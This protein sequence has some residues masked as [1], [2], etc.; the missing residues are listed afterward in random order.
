MYLLQVI[1][2]SGREYLADLCVHCVIT[3]GQRRGSEELEQNQQE[4]LCTFAA[5]KQGIVG[6]VV[7]RSL[8]VL[9]IMYVS[10]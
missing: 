10:L 9:S 8:P 7:D 3:S 5:N 4:Q 2:V 1:V 6:P